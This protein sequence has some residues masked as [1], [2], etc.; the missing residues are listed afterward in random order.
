MRLKCHKCFVQGYT[1]VGLYQS[2]YEPL[3]RKYYID[4]YKFRS[5]SAE[6][7]HLILVY[8]PSSCVSCSCILKPSHL[9]TSKDAWSASVLW[10][11]AT[12][13][14]TESPYL[15]LEGACQ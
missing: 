4:I 8:L 1:V 13:G 15:C 6:K 7:S 3:I 9:P 12:V 11:M 5:E 2:S 14:K 10:G